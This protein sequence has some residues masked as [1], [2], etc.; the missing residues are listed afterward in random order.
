MAEDV[1]LADE[2]SESIIDVLVALAFFVIVI[3]IFCVAERCRLCS[4]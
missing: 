2:V 1:L 4:S 3:K